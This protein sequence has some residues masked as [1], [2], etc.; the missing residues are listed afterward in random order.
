MLKKFASTK[1]L[2]FFIAL[3]NRERAVTPAGVTTTLTWGKIKTKTLE[4]KDP[5]P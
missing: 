1:V 5:P 2:L 4:E 3:P